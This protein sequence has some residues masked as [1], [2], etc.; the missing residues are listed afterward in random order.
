V[1]AFVEIGYN[2]TY[3]VG[4]IVAGLIMDLLDFRWLN[5][6]FLLLIIS[7]LP[8]IH[9]LRLSNLGLEDSDETQS[10][11][12]EGNKL[13]ATSDRPQVYGTI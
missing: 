4:P 8:L 2:F 3:A 5:S 6:I 11:S 7:F 12:M 13:E 10:T 1:L 9:N